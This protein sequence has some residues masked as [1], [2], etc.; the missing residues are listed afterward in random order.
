MKPN[1][2]TEFSPKSVCRY[3]LTAERLICHRLERKRSFGN[4]PSP[5]PKHTGA[6]NPIWRQTTVRNA[7]ARLEQES[8]KGQTL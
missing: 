7:W 4:Y 1:E 2:K 5:I 6:D 8:Q 3:V